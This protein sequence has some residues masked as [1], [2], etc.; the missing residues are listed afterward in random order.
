MLFE[1]HLCILVIPGS[2]VTFL[3]KIESLNID[4]NT[5]SIFRKLSYSKHENQWSICNS[6]SFYR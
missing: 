3:I 6:Q 5:I 4:V 1:F 2:L